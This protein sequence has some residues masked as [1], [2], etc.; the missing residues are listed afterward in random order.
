MLSVALKRFDL[1]RY[2]KLLPVAIS[3]L[4]VAL[5]LLLPTETFAQEG[6]RLR[7]SGFLQP[8]GECMQIAATYVINTLVAVAAWVLYWAGML[9]EAT[10]HFS[11]TTD[12]NSL[13]GVTSG[14]T[15]IR[16]VINLL[17]I[18]IL[19]YIALGTVL[20][21]ESVNWKK[22]LA[23]IIIAAILVNFSLFFTRVAI[24]AS[25]IVSLGLYNKITACTEPDPPLPEPVC[26][27]NGGGDGDSISISE[28][29]MNHIGLARTFGENV[30]GNETNERYGLRN[31]LIRLA[32]IS[33]VVWAFVSIA[34]LFIARS[35]VFVF[36][37]A[38]SPVGVG[39]ASLPMLQEQ[40]GKWREHLFK[41]ALVAPVFLLSMYIILTIAADLLRKNEEEQ[42]AGTSFDFSG[43]LGGESDVAFWLNFVLL[44][45][46]IIASVRLTKSFSGEAGKVINKVGGA[47]VG[48][49]AGLLAGGTAL[50]GR[51][52]VGRMAG[53]AL[54]GGVGRSLAQ[55]ATSQNA[56]VRSG[57]RAGHWAL[58]T[59][60]TASF[61]ARQIRALGIGQ[62]ITRGAEG[63]GPAG[64]SVARAGTSRTGGFAGD[65]ERRGRAIESHGLYQAMSAE[66]LRSEARR[67]G[68]KTPRGRTL[69]RMANRRASQEARE[70]REIIAEDVAGQLEDILSDRIA[71][72]VAEQLGRLSGPQQV[73][74]ALSRLS[75]EQIT[76]S[77]VVSQLGEGDIAALRNTVDRSTL[78]EIV[79]SNDLSERARNYVDNPD[80][81]FPD[82]GRT[83]TAPQSDIEQLAARLED[84]LSAE[85]LRDSVM[86]GMLAAGE[87]MQW[88]QAGG[89]SSGA[90]AVTPA[91]RFA[92][93]TTRE[94]TRN[95][96][97]SMSAENA[98]LAVAHRGGVGNLQNADLVTFALS[99]RG[100]EVGNDA[101]AEMQRRGLSSQRFREDRDEAQQYREE[102]ARAE[103]E[104]LRAQ[105]RERL[106]LPGDPDYKMPPR[107]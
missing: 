84:T 33:L 48:V 88:G 100:T 5:V 80:N 85:N 101:R 79:R 32:L 16:D 21:L 31:G 86:E 25:N 102:Q 74:D 62:A 70:E 55:G 52:V 30:F 98:R 28:A 42:S 51:A 41:Q 93:H 64:T 1:S 8:F 53:A 9:F 97:M 36:L 71:G 20:K 26:T 72:D 77:R 67:L 10:L 106:I 17:F 75:R 40:S 107:S 54:Q 19:L 82:S 13:V 7:C 81:M 46:F 18:F 94:F 105:A 15:V 14:W 95:Q 96:I 23:A 29:I 68:N 37:L 65:Q 34:L 103:T 44:I 45:G 27:G 60:N 92:E 87:S 50:A 99:H 89:E 11:I 6:V 78:T 3:V 57:A 104:E 69:T 66:Q 2:T 73:A 39:G 90:P 12:Y 24:D 59:A 35:V 61:D 63:A 58:R 43:P 56:L 83:F 38:T 4:I 47:V 76:D 49:T 22:Q 91:D